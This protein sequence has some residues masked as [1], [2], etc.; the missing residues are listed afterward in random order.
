LR[1]VFAS[2]DF[3]WGKEKL[4]IGE[5]RSCPISCSQV[6]LMWISGT[7][8][9]DKRKKRRRELAVVF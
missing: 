6:R 4:L 7:Y 3:E 2:E 9:I 5:E 1:V 8:V